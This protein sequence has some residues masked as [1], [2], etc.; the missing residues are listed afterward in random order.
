M[1][2]SNPN[3]A[4]NPQ[5]IEHTLEVPP[6]HTS[7]MRLDKYIASFIQNASRTKVQEAIKEGYVRVN[8]KREQKSYEVQPGDVIEV[9]IPKPPPPEA[10]AE[11]ME[12]DIV[13][14]DDDLLVVNKPAD[15]VVHPAHG[16]WSGTLVNG[17]LYYAD[18]LSEPEEDTIRPGIVHRLD[19]DTSGLLVVAKND[20]THSVLSQYFQTHDIE[21]TYW[22]IVWGTP[23]PEE[24]TIEGAI[25]RSS[26]NRKKMAVVEEDR[27]KHAISHYKILEYF[28]YLSLVEV[29]LE[30]GRTHQIRVHF[31]DIDH[32]VFGDRTYG[33]NSVRYGS[34][35]GSRKQMFKNLFEK[36][37][38]QCL[39]AKT[40]GFEHP[41]TGEMMEFNSELPADFAHVLNMLRQ[42]CKAPY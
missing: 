9:T 28:D 41:S 17:L 39:H 20:H 1:G 29:K 32:P 25:G 15:L 36:M 26:K 19:K 33:G 7:H 11:K 42:N 14:E 12:L 5:Q 31:A 18:E 35:T 30:T 4:V 34:N 3:G 16:N 8:K 2:N 22:A 27:G 10:N 38:R 21:R 37:P 24:G 40:L 23:E 13:Y 6:G